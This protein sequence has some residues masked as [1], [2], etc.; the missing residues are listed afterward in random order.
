MLDSSK[1]LH[2]IR[3]KTAART[4]AAPSIDGNNRARKL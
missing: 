2:E 3:S 4:G 1:V